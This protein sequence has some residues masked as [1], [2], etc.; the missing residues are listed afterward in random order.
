METELRILEAKY[1]ALRKQL[2]DKDKFIET[3]KNA[4]KIGKDMEKQ[5]VAFTKATRTLLMKGV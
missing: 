2:Q 5:V 1:H 4:S 3:V